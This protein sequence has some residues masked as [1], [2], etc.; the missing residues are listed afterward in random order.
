MRTKKINFN[1]K[2][3]ELVN[4]LTREIP[5]KYLAAYKVLLD[6]KYPIVDSQVFYEQLEKVKENEFVKELLI[7]TFTPRDFGLE[8]P[9]NALE[10]FNLNVRMK[11]IPP[12]EFYN[13]PLEYRYERIPRPGYSMYTPYKGYPT[14]IPFENNAFPVE[15][16]PPLEKPAY[17]WPEWKMEKEYIPTRM[18]TAWKEWEFGK[19]IIGDVTMSLFSEMVS[20]G[21]R[22]DYAYNFAREKEVACR[23]IIPTF[24]VELTEKALFIFATH[25][26]LLG[27]GVRKSYWTARFFLDK[28]Y[29]EFEKMEPKARYYESFSPKMKKEF[30]EPV[31]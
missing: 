25:F 13:Y 30:V 29:F 24:E 17:Y 3:G 2:S 22:E 31:M 14:G 6:L 18:T 9:I 4:F 7:N 23:R 11:S 10:K 15:K 28:P 1:G 27:K 20:K 16:Y 5:Q 26:I 21:I 19:D 8:S 12:F